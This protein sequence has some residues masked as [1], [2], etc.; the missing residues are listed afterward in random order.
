MNASIFILRVSNVALG[1]KIANPYFELLRNFSK[2][3][4]LRPFFVIGFGEIKCMELFPELKAL[5]FE[6]NGCGSLKGLETNT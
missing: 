1:A 6:G 5:Y 4:I 3:R 2:C